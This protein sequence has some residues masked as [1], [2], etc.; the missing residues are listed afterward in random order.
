[1]GLNPDL[2]TYWLCD[3]GQV[4]NFSVN[5]ITTAPTSSGFGGWGLSEIKV[6]KVQS[7]LPGLRNHAVNGGDYYQVA[8]GWP[9]NVRALT[10]APTVSAAAW[11]AAICQPWALQLAFPG[12]HSHDCGPY[13][14]SAGPEEPL[15]ITCFVV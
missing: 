9:C 3:P 10:S 4:I 6:Y 5:E 8:A 11:A 13:E 14:D 7:T 15:Y 2:S 1:M 12:A